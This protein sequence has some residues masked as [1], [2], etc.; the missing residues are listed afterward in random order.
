MTAPATTKGV[1]VFVPG[2]P[3]AQGSLKAFRVGK[4]VRLT[5]S[6]SRLMS[7]RQDVAAKVQEAAE[8]RQF[9]G[10][11]VLSLTF[12]FQRPRSHFGTG[13]NAERLKPT[14]PQQHHAQ[15]PDVDKLARAACD[16]LTVSGVIRDDSQIAELNA[17]KRWLSPDL[18]EGPGV[19]IT[20]ADLGG[21]KGEN[22][23]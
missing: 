15:A 5:Q 11:V 22:L 18:N 12:W 2:H 19:A 16:A 21:V 10:P 9:T 4:G 23:A 7:W 3:E 17:I 8:G 14:A 6:N 1:R 13:R 20:L